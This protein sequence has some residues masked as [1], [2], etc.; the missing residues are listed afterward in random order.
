MS[1][2]QKVLQDYVKH[3]H[4]SSTAAFWSVGFWSGLRTAEGLVH[5]VS[6]TQRHL[7]GT[8]ILANSVCSTSDKNLKPPEE[9]SLHITISF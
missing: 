4:L 3:V 6:R 5:N 7:R 8:S 9:S 1:S 2:V